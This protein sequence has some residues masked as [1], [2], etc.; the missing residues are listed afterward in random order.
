MVMKKALG[1]KDSE[2]Y[3]FSDL[4]TKDDWDESLVPKGEYVTAGDL[5]KKKK[6]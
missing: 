6:K 2:D 3:K 5:I 1:L 4:L